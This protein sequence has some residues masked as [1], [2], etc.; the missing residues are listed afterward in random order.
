MIRRKPWRAGRG[1][2]PLRIGYGRI[3]HEA[4][5]FS[6]LP[7]DVDAFD[8]FHRMEG[9][10]LARATHLAGGV[11]LASFMPHAE[12]TGFVQAAR[13]AGDVEAVPLSSALAVPGGPISHRVFRVLLDQLLQATKDAGPLD[14]IYL[15][16]HGSMQVDGLDD[17]PE[18][19][20]LREVMAAAPG[21]RIAVSYDLHGNLSK[22]MVEPVD[23][24][25]AYRTNPHWDL[26]PTGFR[27]GNRLI[28]A[29]RDQVRPTHAWRKLP[30]V[31]GGGMTIDFL[32]PM[33][34]VFGWMKDLERDPR[35]LTASLFMVHPFTDADDLGWAT[36]V[37]T[38]DDPDLADRLVDQLSDRAWAQRHETPPPM[39]TVAQALDEVRSAWWRRLGPTVFVD[40]DDIVGAGAPGGNT[41]VVQAMAEDDRGLVA[42]VPVHDPALLRE[43]WDAP[44]GSTHRVTVRGT[45]GY[46]QPAVDLDVEVGPRAV[47]NGGRTLRLDAG[48]L[49]LAVCEAP[50]LPIHPSFWSPLG[51]SARQ[52]DVIVQKNFFHYRMFYAT[53][54]VRHLPVVSAGATS[55]QRLTQRSYPV[56]MHP[57]DR[58]D[59]WRSSDNTLRHRRWRSHDETERDGDDTQAAFVGAV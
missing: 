29:L 3:F 55:L 43:L 15:A 6:P 5:A 51:L 42:Y 20:I 46:G 18:A 47:L 10:T 35:V 59:D 30:L 48:G 53:T 41:H 22:N 45:P 28:R 27:A 12:L 14:G 50:P 21:A 25:V 58:V 38:D 34:G 39:R 26:A 19:V 16:L 23:I 32:A 7:T 40:V 33:R 44:V 56:P 17:A 9:S 13:V 36:H 49:K 1:G 24:M 52:A 31:L 4:C 11:E 54:A 2:R 8:R 57:K 37:C